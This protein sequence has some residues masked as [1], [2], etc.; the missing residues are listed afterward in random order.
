MAYAKDTAYQASTDGIVI[1]HTSIDSSAGGID[2][3]TDSS[4]PPTTTRVREYHQFDSG[5]TTRFT[6]VMPVKKND[7]WKISASGDASTVTIFF[8]PMGS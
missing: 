3:L 5:V 1:A 2:G 4:N 8:I 7:Y 6:L